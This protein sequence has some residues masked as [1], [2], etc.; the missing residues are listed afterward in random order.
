MLVQELEGVGELNVVR[1]G[2]CDLVLFY[3]LPEGWGS[4][5]FRLSFGNFVAIPN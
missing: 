2:H 5:I 1:H 4:E 3:G